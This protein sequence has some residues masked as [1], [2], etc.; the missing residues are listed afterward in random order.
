MASQGIVSPT[1]EQ[2]RAALIGPSGATP[3]A[4]PGILQ[5]RAAGM[6]WGQ[7]ALSTGVKLGAVMIGKPSFASAAGSV[8][9]HGRGVTTGLGGGGYAA[10]AAVHASDGR[11]GGGA[12][13]SN[14]SGLG[15]GKL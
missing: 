14:A 7:I 8:G 9:S 5:M 11:T 1:A 4:A 3:T 12:T 15:R 6:G 13:V 2:L 10:N